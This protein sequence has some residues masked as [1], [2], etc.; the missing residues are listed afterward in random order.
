MPGVDLPRRSIAEL[1]ARY[2]LEP[3]IAD[4]FVEGKF[5]ADVL[6]WFFS[7]IE[8]K[9][10]AVY[11]ID[12]VDVPSSI[13]RQYTMTDGNKQRVLALA[14]ELQPN[15][16]QSQV[17]CV[18]DRDFDGVGG[19]SQVASGLILRTD[20]SSM[21]LYLFAP[22]VLDKLVIKV[23]GDRARRGEELLQKIGHVSRACFSIRF[24]HATADVQLNWIP[25]TRCCELDRSGDIIFDQATFLE[26]VLHKSSAFKSRDKIMTA[27][28]G[29]AELTMEFRLCAHG[30]DAASVLAW[31]LNQL[32]N[33]IV[34]EPENL[35]RI[36]LGC[37]ELRDIASE[38]MFVELAR[39]FVPAKTSAL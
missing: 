22:R 29:C 32:G 1:R 11:Q 18:V 30:H 39:R 38:P 25:P 20:G 5:D 10:V 4:V 28:Q 6:S 17:A 34:R 21:E 19:T 12:T 37:L 27:M 3:S 2:D 26:R 15:A 13:L 31:Y 33:D 8:Y 24:A 35:I 7:E 9:H 16:N 36:L 23:L 14:L